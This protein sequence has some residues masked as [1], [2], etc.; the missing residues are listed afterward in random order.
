MYWSGRSWV[1]A[2]VLL[3]GCGKL[4]YEPTDPTDL[5]PDG[6][7]A[8]WGSTGWRGGFSSGS[9]TGGRR[10]FADG[11]HP[12]P[13]AYFPAGTSCYRFDSAQVSWMT[14]EARCENEGAHLAVIDDANEDALLATTAAAGTTFWIGLT[15]SA[16]EGRFTWVTGG[17]PYANWAIGEPDATSGQE[18]YVEVRLTDHRWK[19]NFASAASA[20]VCEYDGVA[21]P[22]PWPA[23]SYCDTR[24]DADCGACGQACPSGTHCIDPPACR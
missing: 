6:G 3:A 13:Y 16:S 19:S 18:D 7:V 4:G 9:G 2:G 21:S 15:D 22:G 11:S 10:G 24:S 23:G 17:G 20:Y 1:L 12:C 8:T 14:A 5:S